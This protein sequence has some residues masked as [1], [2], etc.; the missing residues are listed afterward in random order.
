MAD[1]A[2]MQRY[3]ENRQR[4]IDG[5]AYDPASERDAC[6][7]GLVCAIDGKPRREVV[8]LAIRALKSVWHRGAIDADGKTGDGAGVLVSVPQ[9]FFADQVK[10]TGHKLRPGPIVEA[11]ALR[12]GFYIYGWRQVPTDTRVIGEKANATRPEIEQIMLAGPTGL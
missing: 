11:E 5:G 1:D 10:R 4:L 2:Q 8:E 6:G 7:V 3:F 12:F 9:D